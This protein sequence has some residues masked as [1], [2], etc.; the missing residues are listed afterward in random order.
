MAVQILPVAFDDS[1]EMMPVGMAAFANDEL[2]KASYP[3]VSMNQSEL[4]SHLQWRTE[5]LRARIS[6]IGKHWFKAIDS[7]SGKIIGFSGIYDP[8]AD[9]TPSSNPLEEGATK[10]PSPSPQEQINERQK[11]ILGDR[12]DIWYVPSMAVHPDHSGKGV[13][14]KLLA[15]VLELPDKAGQDVYLAATPSGL[16]LYQRAGFVAHDTILLLDGKYSLAC[17]VRPAGGQQNA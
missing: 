6:G 14:T 9:R 15:K 11:K 13:A 2:E 8:R 7:E 3:T 10:N 1:A 17:M 5:R 16:K 12:K 4:D